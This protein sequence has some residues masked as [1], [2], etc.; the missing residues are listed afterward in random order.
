MNFKAVFYPF[1]RRYYTTSFSNWVCL[2][3]FYYFDAFT[4]RYLILLQI[5]PNYVAL[6]YAAWIV[7]WYARLRVLRK[8]LK[9]RT[10]LRRMKLRL[11]CKYEQNVINN[12]SVCEL[13]RFFKQNY[14]WLK[15]LWLRIWTDNDWTIWFGRYQIFKTKW[16]MKFKGQNQKLSSKI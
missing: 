16:E 12:N 4:A 2:I 13:K 10:N 8:Q 9:S 1:W 6:N 11:R 3:M 15:W 7:I 5:N 14:R